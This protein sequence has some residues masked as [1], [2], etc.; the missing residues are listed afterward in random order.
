MPRIKMFAT[1]AVLLMT[2]FALPAAHALPGAEVDNTYYDADLNIVGEKDILC[3]GTHYTWGIT[4]GTAFM[5][6]MSSSC[7]SGF[8][9]TGCYQWDVNGYTQVPLAHCGLF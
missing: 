5:S 2:L 9:T 7:D 3:D 8:G 6:S 4:N 1:A